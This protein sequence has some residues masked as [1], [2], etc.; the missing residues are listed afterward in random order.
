VKARAVNAKIESLGGVQVR[1]R[2]SHRRYSISYTD[3]E[4]TTRTVFT[5]VQQHPS[6]DIPLGTLK[7]IERDLVPALGK[8]WLL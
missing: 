4:K 1:Q 6:K 3:V 7:A 2:G 8:G 5:T